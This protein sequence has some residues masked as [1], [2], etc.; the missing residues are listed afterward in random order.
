MTTPLEIVLCTVVDIPPDVKLAGP[1]FKSKPYRERIVKVKSA[2]R[3]DSQ[4]HIWH[5]Y[6][7][8]LHRVSS[9]YVTLPKQT[10]K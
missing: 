8:L 5:A 6:V 1:D 3:K 10:C 9:R 4:G 7:L 2:I